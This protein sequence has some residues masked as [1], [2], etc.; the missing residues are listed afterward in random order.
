MGPDWLNKYVNLNIPRFVC[1]NIC[2]NPQDTA[3]FC[4]FKKPISIALDPYQTLRGNRWMT[5]TLPGFTLVVGPVM[6][7]LAPVIKVGRRWNFRWF[8]QVQRWGPSLVV[9]IPFT[10]QLSWWA[11]LLGATIATAGFPCF[12]NGLRND[13]GKASF[14]T[15]ATAINSSIS[16]KTGCAENRGTRFIRCLKTR[17]RW[18]GKQCN[19]ATQTHVES[20]CVSAFTR[21]CRTQLIQHIS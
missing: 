3:P 13:T 9:A 18:I 16:F 5:Q 4:I 8:P 17:M 11:C 10:A 21:T 7:W 12:F 14:T 1:P 2:Q 15:W 20:A 6:V 19:C